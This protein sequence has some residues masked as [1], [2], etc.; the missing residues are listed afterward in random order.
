ML[1]EFAKA[2]NEAITYMGAWVQAGVLELKSRNRPVDPGMSERHL[3]WIGL[4]LESQEIMTNLLDP[5]KS[6]D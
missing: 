5:D 3:A 6:D 1:K 2:P 4:L